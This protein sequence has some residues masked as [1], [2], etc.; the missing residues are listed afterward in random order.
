MMMSAK[1]KEFVYI[2]PKLIPLST[3]LKIM[4]ACHVM[5]RSLF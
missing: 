1:E 5:Y 2:W 4:L 3:G